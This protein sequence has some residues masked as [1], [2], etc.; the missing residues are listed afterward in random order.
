MRGSQLRVD[1]HPPEPEN[2][3]GGGWAGVEG[4]ERERTEKNK[5]E[6]DSIIV[7]VEVIAVDGDGISTGGN[8]TE[9]KDKVNQQ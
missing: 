9:G 7:M 3:C 2:G 4:A 8:S 1:G 5:N 6:R